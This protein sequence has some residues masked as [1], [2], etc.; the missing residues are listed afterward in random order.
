MHI[1]VVSGSQTSYETYESSSQKNASGVQ[2]NVFSNL[3]PN[4]ISTHFIEL[5]Q[6]K[7]LDGVIRLPQIQNVPTSESHYD[8][9]GITE[10]KEHK[11]NAIPIETAYSQY[12]HDDQIKMDEFSVKPAGALV[13]SVQQGNYQIN[14]ASLP[15]AHI[16]QFTVRLNAPAANSQTYQ[17]KEI[18]SSSQTSSGRQVPVISVPLSYTKNS[19]YNQFDGIVYSHSQSVPASTFESYENQGS[20]SHVLSSQQVPTA[21]VQSSSFIS[22][23]KH[24]GS[25][26]SQKDSS[27][28][29]ISEQISSHD[30]N[31]LSLQSYGYQSP[32]LLH[33]VPQDVQFPIP[34][35]VHGVP[36]TQSQSFSSSSDS[37]S[38]SHYSSSKVAGSVYPSGLYNDADLS[39]KVRGASSSIY[40][41][42][43]ENSEVENL[44]ASC[45]GGISSSNMPIKNSY[46]V[47]KSFSS[48][49]KTINGQM[50]ENREASVAV[51]D[52]GKVDSYHVRS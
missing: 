8:V 51:N 11:Y 12:E 27:V 33:G 47:S 4:T 39:Q 18:S 2:S 34:L 43:S 41:K 52:N 24:Q 31:A 45:I 26:Y 17:E 48:N 22:T 49:S 37:R 3:K 7:G 21:P 13:S 10:Q 32:V 30:K 40:D 25:T 1:P 19:Q 5:S 50:T 46:A 29:V 44:C 28:P 20:S 9:S 36:Q 14:T 16:E 6:E 38:G 15:T 35:L 23:S 42:H